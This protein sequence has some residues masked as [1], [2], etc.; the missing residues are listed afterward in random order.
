MTGLHG[1]EDGAIK[2]LAK[3]LG[4]S[5]ADECRQRCDLDP[6]CKEYLF[7]LVSGR[8]FRQCWLYNGK[9][10]PAVKVHVKSKRFWTHWK[11]KGKPLAQRNIRV[12]DTSYTTVQPD[13]GKFFKFDYY[14]W[15]VKMGRRP[16]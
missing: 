14:L 15:R 4:V 9:C 1:C 7:G 13:H 10:T 5:R 16:R 6:Q 3:Y 2:P 12:L 8:V 11:C